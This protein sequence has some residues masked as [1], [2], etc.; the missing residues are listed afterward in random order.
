MYNRG[1]MEIK[2]HGDKKQ[3]KFPTVEKFVYFSIS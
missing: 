3:R 2:A 1:R